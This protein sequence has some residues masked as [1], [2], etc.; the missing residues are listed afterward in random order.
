MRKI[1]VLVILFSLWHKHSAY[2]QQPPR[3]YHFDFTPEETAAIQK[4]MA[5][6]PFGE[7]SQFMF[8]FN[9]EI[10]QQN[11]VFQ[12]KSAPTPAPV[13]TPSPVPTP[14]PTPAPKE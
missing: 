6:L 3:Y 8:H 2:A 1:L 10:N 13:A 11:A 9:S 14:A 12:A 5:L 4:Q 7:I